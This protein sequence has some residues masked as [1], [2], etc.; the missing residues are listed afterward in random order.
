MWWGLPW[1]ILMR[2]E[3]VAKSAAYFC[4]SLTVTLALDGISHQSPAQSIALSEVKVGALAHDIPFL[5][6]GKEHGADFNAEVMLKS[7]FPADWAM[8]LGNKFGWVAQPRPT[9]GTS[10]NTSG[11]TSQVYL[12][13]TWTIP[14][15][16]AVMSDN[17]GLY[18]GFEFGPSFNNGRVNSSRDDR[19]DLGSNVLF[20][21]GLEI[22]YQVTPVVS[23]SILFDHESNAGLA[24]KNDGL[25]SLGARL[26]WRF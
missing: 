25:D 26:G 6:S 21:E 8:G 3:V 9:L 24:R 16:S 20:R 10:L 1:P 4:L 18:L 17:D 13:L 15:L 14:L 19:K 7:P 11:Y 22:G 12:G 2:G 5:A 23:V